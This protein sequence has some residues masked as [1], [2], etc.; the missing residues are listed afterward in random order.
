MTRRAVRVTCAGCG[1]VE[2][3]VGDLRCE[4]RG[5]QGI[6]EFA[7][8]FCQRLALAKMQAWRALALQA[9]G[10]A[11]MTGPI[12][13]ELLEPH[14]GPVVSW[15]EALDY[16]LALERTDCPQAELAPGTELVEQAGSATR[17]ARWPGPLMYLR[18]SDGDV[19]ARPSRR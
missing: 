7:C 18:A 2:C 15:D 8:P 9:L 14:E 6:L 17:T 19:A 11:R 12:P 13:F 10:A 16:H 5:S 3:P 4:A 1:Q